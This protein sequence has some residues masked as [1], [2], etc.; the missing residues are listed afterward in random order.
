M[1]KQLLKFLSALLILCGFSLSADI[2]DDLD[3]DIDSIEKSYWRAICSQ[4][5][6]EAYFISIR[7]LLD[8]AQTKAD[9]VQQSLIANKCTSKYGNINKEISLL[10]N[11]FRDY[12]MSPVRFFKINVPET[13]M[14]AYNSQFQRTAKAKKNKLLKATLSNVDI[15]QYDRWIMDIRDKQSEV[16]YNYRAVSQKKRPKNQDRRDTQIERTRQAVNEYLAQ[17]HKIRLLMVDIRQT[18]N[19]TLKARQR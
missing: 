19:R 15:E 2:L 7:N 1:K 4:Q 9:L 3:K 12:G 8:R 17:I 14:E 5:E 10:R 11:R 6:D 18:I 16:K 13:S